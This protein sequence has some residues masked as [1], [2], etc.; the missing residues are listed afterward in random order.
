MFFI[1]DNQTEIG[2]RAKQRRARADKN[3]LFFSDH[4]PPLIGFFA[5]GEVRVKDATACGKRREK[6]SISCGVKAISGTRTR[7]CLR[8][9][10]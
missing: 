5:F 6:R 1:E 7:A 8:L 4:A 9:R 2:K 10:K 3:F